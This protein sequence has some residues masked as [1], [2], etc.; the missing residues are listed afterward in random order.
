VIKTLKL[1][2]MAFPEGADGKY[3]LLLPHVLL[4]AGRANFSSSLG[5]RIIFL[6]YSR[7]AIFKI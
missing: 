6:L 2:R 1:Y 5:S 3:D 7:K 4:N